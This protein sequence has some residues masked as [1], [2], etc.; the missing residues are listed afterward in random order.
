[1]VCHV[2]RSGLWGVL[3]RDRGLQ[4]CHAMGDGLGL[5]ALW[6]SNHPESLGGVCGIE[7]HMNPRDDNKLTVGDLICYSFSAD[8]CGQT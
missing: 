1:M 2:K 4:L 5:G 3:G 6:F 8:L 7:I